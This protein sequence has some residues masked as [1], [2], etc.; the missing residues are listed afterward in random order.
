MSTDLNDAPDGAGRVVRVLIVDDD[1]AICNLLATLLGLWGFE[2]ITVHSGPEALRAEQLHRP[3]I[4]LLDVVMP[5][6]DGSEVAKLVRA[7]AHVKRRRPFIV[8][9]SGHP[10]AQNGQRAQ[11]AG[12]DLHYV[13]P[14]NPSHLQRLLRRFQRM[15]LPSAERRLSESHRRP[16]RDSSLRYWSD[17]ATLR[18]SLTRG[19]Q[20][21][22]A[23]EALRFKHRGVRNRQESIQL[24][25]AWCDQVAQLLDENERGRR[26]V[27][28]FVKWGIQTATDP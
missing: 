18:Q 16:W 25:A 1:R 26:L 4:I 21:L 27:R 13:K 17:L 19:R 3:D 5:G 14:L 8:S 6:M 28:S 10:N 12:I 24:R 11:E 2:V 7:R 22:R 23:A 9:M 20:V 15:I